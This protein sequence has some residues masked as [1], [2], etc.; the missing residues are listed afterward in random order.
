M[1]D[2][3]ERILNLAL[4][5]AHAS[6]PISTE[7]IRDD[8]EGYSPDQDDAAFARM[9][10]RDKDE[11]RRAGFALRFDE[12]N[13]TYTLDAAAT[14]AHP[15]SLTQ[16]EAAAVRVAGVALLDDPSFPFAADLRLAL[17]KI[18]EQ[19]AG[20][21]VTASSLLADETPHTQREYA[22]ALALAVENRKLVTFDY[23]NSAGASAPHEVEPYGLFL[24]DGRWYLVG[25]DTALD[26]QRTYTLM[27]MTDL[28]PN[29]RAPKSP[30]FKRPEEF[31]VSRFVRLPFQYGPA[32]SEFTAVIRFAPGAAWRAAAVTAG[33]GTLSQKDGA[34]EW[35]VS[36]R[37]AA[38]LLRFL[39]ENG[40]GLEPLKPE[41]LAGELAAG[42]AR[43]EVLHG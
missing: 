21:E 40:P 7:R 31:D 34:V 5:L 35:S 17:A 28:E 38:A 15:L 39:V 11:L 27:R 42:C 37:D 23:T 36:A 32:D 20:G 41:S 3:V 6:E 25:R 22:H 24:H 13:N 30:D 4:C 10:E 16:G 9:F 1:I 8:V 19:T 14:F 43:V 18:A 29:S 26:E 12:E 33:H 2:A